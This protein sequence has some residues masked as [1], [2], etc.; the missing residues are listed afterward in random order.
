M[1][2]YLGLFLSVELEAC[3]PDLFGLSKRREGEGRTL[4]WL[5]AWALLK[6]D[7]SA[8]LAQACPE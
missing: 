7:I 8:N 6:G 2:V 5:A 4:G 1:Y 3:S